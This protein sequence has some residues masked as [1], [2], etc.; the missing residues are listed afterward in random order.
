MS[1][2]RDSSGSGPGRELSDAELEALYREVDQEPP[3]ALDERVLAAARRRRPHGARPRWLRP[4]TG[5]A[6]A[7][8]VVLAVAIL[9]RAPAPT[10]ESALPP[11]RPAE[12]AGAADDRSGSVAPA[13]RA[14]AGRA[15]PETRVQAPAPA[16]AGEGR[17]ASGRAQTAREQKATASERRRESPAAPPARTAPTLEEIVVTTAQEPSA[18]DAVAPGGADADLEA[19]EADDA[20]QAFRPETLG[21]LTGRLPTPAPRA[22]YAAPGCPEPYPLPDGAVV[23]IAE[24]GLQITVGGETFLVRCVD[25]AWARQSAAGAPQSNR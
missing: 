3:P 13:D 24:D 5:F 9:L 18:R 16:P 20:G 2:H 15:E 17:A 8:V 4:A 19:R 12:S 25:G 23:E 21:A 22:A 10:P 11:A 6:T 7:A 14:P 1:D